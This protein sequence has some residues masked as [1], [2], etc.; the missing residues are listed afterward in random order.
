MY[1]RDYL[2]RLI[3]EFFNFIARFLKL[4]VE[5][6]YD[7]ALQVLDEASEKLLK[8]PLTIWSKDSDVE[9]FIVENTALTDVQFEI[10]G[11]LLKNRADIFLLQF[12]YEDAEND[13]VTALKLLTHSQKISSSFSIERE[14]MIAEIQKQL[15]S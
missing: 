6:N 12:K 15:L 7:E 10:M 14:N 9:A 5:G 3:E 11:S 13:Y 1:R 2:L 8:M 4:K